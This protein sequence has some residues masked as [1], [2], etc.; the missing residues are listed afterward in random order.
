VFTRV[1]L[2]CDTWDGHFWIARDPGREGLV[3][4]TGGSGHAY[5]FAPRLGALSADAVEGRENDY[6]RKF[7]WRPEIHP[8][9]NEEA[10][11]CQDR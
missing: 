4:A 9:Q 2:Y 11:R 7:R 6:S 10:A 1:C 8:E 5:K 3:L